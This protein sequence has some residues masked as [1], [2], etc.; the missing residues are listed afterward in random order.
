MSNHHKN[1]DPLDYVEDFDYDL[2]ED[3]IEHGI[4][5]NCNGSGEAS[6][7]GSTCYVC[8]GKGEV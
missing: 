6:H 3:D 7:D 4:C 1:Y 8:G 5:Y 2:D